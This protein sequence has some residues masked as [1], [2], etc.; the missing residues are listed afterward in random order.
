MD[1]S[2]QLRQWNKIGQD[3]WFKFQPGWGYEQQI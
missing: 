2:A 3:S 1:M